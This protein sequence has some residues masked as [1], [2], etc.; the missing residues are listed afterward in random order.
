V[1]QDFGALFV[2]YGAD[3]VQLAT[4][5]GSEMAMTAQRVVAPV[6]MGVVAVIAFGIW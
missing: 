4:S 2:G 5:A 3:W 1:R 6:T